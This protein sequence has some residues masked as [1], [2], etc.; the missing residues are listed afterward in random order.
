MKKTALLSFIV[1]LF[2]ACAPS[3]YKY[4]SID[5]SF[6]TEDKSLKELSFAHKI[7][8]EY[9]S[10]KEFDKTYQMELPHLRF[11]KSLDWYKNFFEPNRKGYKITL[12]S[13]N[14]I[15]DDRAI[16]THRYEDEEENTL[17]IEDRWVLIG[18]KWRHYFEFSKLPS[19]E[20]PF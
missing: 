4:S 13:I 14:K 5:P 11:Q 7:Y 17:I 19:A 20:S 8:W 12:L 1:L 15:D 9:Y 10:A 6:T 2:A 3:S 18:G 16:I